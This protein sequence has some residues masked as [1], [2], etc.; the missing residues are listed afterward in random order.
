MQRSGYSQLDTASFNGAKYLKRPIESL[1]VQADLFPYR[2]E[3]P[4]SSLALAEV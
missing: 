1:R 3:G 4:L 2:A